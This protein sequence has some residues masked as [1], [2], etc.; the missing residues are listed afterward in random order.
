MLFRPSC[1][2]ETWDQDH[3]REENAGGQIAQ[4]E[5]GCGEVPERGPE[6]KGRE[7]GCPVVGFTSLGRNAVD[8]QR[9]LAALPEPEDHGQDDR[10]EQGCSH[11]G[12]M[13]VEMQ[14]I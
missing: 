2:R 3:D 14:E 6:G 5:R 4:V 12:N 13:H 8:G 7:Y 9:A 10:P 11:I 1:H